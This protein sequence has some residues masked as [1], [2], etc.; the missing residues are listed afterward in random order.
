MERQGFCARLYP[1]REPRGYVLGDE[2]SPPPKLPFLMIRSD[3]TIKTRWDVWIALLIVYSILIVPVRV[4][5]ALRA[6][7]LAADWWWDLIVD[8][9]FA[10]DILLCF[11]TATVVEDGARSQQI[12]ITN[13]RVLAHR[14]LCGWFFVDLLSTIPVDTIVDFVALLENWRFPRDYEE[15]PRWCAA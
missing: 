1:D 10:I 14:Y 2:E 13:P 3:A 5:F 15:F 12:L 8:T 6:C 7:I 11:R 9:C 4:G